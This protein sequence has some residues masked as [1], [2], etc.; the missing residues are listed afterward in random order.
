MAELVVALSFRA[1]A[2]LCAVLI[3]AL[4]GGVLAQADGDTANASQADTRVE[5]QLFDELARETPLSSA[6]H[7]VRAAEAFDWT[8]AARYLD[9]RNLPPEA[10]QLS[11]EELAEKFYFILQRREVRVDPELISDDPEGHSLDDLPDYRDHLAQVRTQDGPVTLLMQRVPGSDGLRVWKVSNQTVGQVPA[12]YE[13]FRYPDWVERIRETVPGDYHF[14]GVELFKWLII[15]GA[16]VLVTPLVWGAMYLLARL[17]SGPPS[18]LWP[19]YRRL[20]TGSVTALIVVTAVV[21][22]IYELGVGITMIKALKTHTL[23]TIVIVWLVWQ[24]ADLW[25]ARRRECYLA[26]GRSDAA[27]LGRPV[28][29]AVKLLA[30]LI[31]LLIWLANA[32]VDISA[33]LAGLG[34]GGIAVALALQKPIEDLFGAIS[35][36]SQQ[37]VSTGDLCRY[38]DSLGVVEEIGLRTTRIR[39]LSNTLVNV[40]NAQLSSGII[41]NLTARTK[42]MYQ[43]DLP[44]RYDTSRE[45]LLALLPALEEM[46][47]ANPLVEDDTVR[48][49]LREFGENA[50]IVRIRA[51]AMTR[52]VEEYLMIVQEIN[53]EIMNIMKENNVSFSQGAQTLFI[54]RGDGAAKT[55]GS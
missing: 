2:A 20:L 34:I 4:P 18:P 15:I 30:V 42:I 36:Y 31:G 26:E 17:I 16:L 12:L 33:L 23:H 22:L 53:L 10:R 47:R 8:L 14:L 52:S 45:Q 38:G 3:L 37:P 9:L 54:K 32:G 1:R 46:L 48:V 41:E 5:E 40:P 51:F 29:N 21:N 27:I 44:L 11:G 19:D 43:P 55:P 49:R 28:A 25:R 35:I 13:Q 50:I 6:T 7:F 24:L 39:T